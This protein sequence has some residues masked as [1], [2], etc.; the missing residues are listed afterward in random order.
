MTIAINGWR[1]AIAQE[2]IKMVGVDSCYLVIRGDPMP[3]YDKSARFLFCQGLLAS[4][5]MHKQ[6]LTFQRES[7]HTNFEWIRDQC[8]LIIRANDLARICVIGSES[9]FTGSFDGSYALAKSLLHAYV[10]RKTLRTVHQQLV[11]VAPSIIK[12]AGMTLRRQDRDNLERRAATH[13][14]GRFIEAAEVARLVHFLLYEDR[15]YISGVTIRMNG[16]AH[17]GHG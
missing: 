17:N 6:D 4:E 15:G 1:S 7:L 11:C 16:G 3:L 14:K 2:L 13:P 8:D 9:G 12:D 5:N 10:E